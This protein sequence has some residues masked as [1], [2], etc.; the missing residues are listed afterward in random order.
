[1]EGTRVG[2]NGFGRMG[3]LA[4]RAAWGWPELSF[5][6]VNELNGDAADTSAHLLTFDSVHG[7][8]AHDVHGARGRALRSTDAPSATA[9]SPSP[10]RCRGASSASTSCSSAP[11]RFRT[12]EPLDAV[13]RARRAQGHRRRAGQGR[14]R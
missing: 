1:M 12:R 4:L 9:A 14:A 3:R 11:G 10:A 7:R 8:W 2:I 6:H 5:V 13:L